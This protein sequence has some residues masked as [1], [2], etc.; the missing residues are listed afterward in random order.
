MRFDQGEAHAASLRGFSGCAKREEA[1]A[2]CKHVVT[3]R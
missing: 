3:F 1:I 2:S